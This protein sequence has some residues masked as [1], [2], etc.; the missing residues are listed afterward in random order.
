M[1]K[2][3]IFWSIFISV[4]IGVVVTL[5]LH[6]RQGRGRQATRSPSASEK[7]AATTVATLERTGTPRLVCIGGSHH[8]HRFAIPPKGLAIGRALDNDLVIVDGSISAH[9]AWIGIVDGRVLLRDYQS[10]KGTFLNADMASR[11]SEAVLADG[12]TIFFGGDGAVP[13]RVIFE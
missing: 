9:H 6:R 13:Y 3:Y 2:H 4:L 7:T 1:L 12:D 8:G 11:V 5:A 10:L